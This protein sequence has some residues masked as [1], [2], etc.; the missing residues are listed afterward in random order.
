VSARLSVPFGRTTATRNRQPSA[1][2]FFLFF[3]AL[4]QPKGTEEEVE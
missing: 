3:M 1:P 2:S 4:W